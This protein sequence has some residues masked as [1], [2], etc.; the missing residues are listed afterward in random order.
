MSR[1]E[2]ERKRESRRRWHKNQKLLEEHD[3]LRLEKIKE[4]DIKYNRERQLK[5]GKIYEHD[6][7]QIQVMIKEK[8]I[9]SSSC[10]YNTNY[11]INRDINVNDIIIPR[12]K[13]EGSRPIFQRKEIKNG[14]V[15]LETLKDSKYIF[16]QDI[17]KEHHVQESKTSNRKRNDAHHTHCDDKI[18]HD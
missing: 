1:S 14:W 9:T 13:D 15:E 4:F 2:L 5:N 7:R 16:V 18:I 6:L 17:K 11:Q 10:N 12:K 3:K 8:K